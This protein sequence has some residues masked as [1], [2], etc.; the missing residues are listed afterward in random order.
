MISQGI[1]R[2][3]ASTSNIVGNGFSPFYFL[4]YPQFTGAVNVI[5]SNDRSRYNALE[6]QLSRR[7]ANGLSFQGSYTL[8]KSE[9]TRSFDPAFA[10]ANR[11]ATGHRRP[12][13]RSTSAPRDL[14]YARRLRPA[15]ALQGYA[16]YDRRSGGD[17]GSGT[18]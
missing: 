3:T 12:V 10:V 1:R 7:F 4:P 16:F 9:D 18:N 15:H 14:N 2:G 8:A 6:V 11:A 17:V 5:D 13:R